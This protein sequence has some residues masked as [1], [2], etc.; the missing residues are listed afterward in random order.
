M[1]TNFKGVLPGSQG[2]PS[3]KL[4]SKNYQKQME[5]EQQKEE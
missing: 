2:P 4:D 3:N 1:E 5:K